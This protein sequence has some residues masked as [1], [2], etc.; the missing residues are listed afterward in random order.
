[1]QGL[2]GRLRCMCLAWAL[3]PF[4][5]AAP[6]L[7]SPWAE[8]GDNALRSDIEILAAAGIIDNLTSHWPLP[9]TAIARKIEAA[10]LA[11]QPAS[12]RDAADRVLARAHGE[13]ADG[14][15]AK[16][17]I[18]LTNRP[19][20]VYDF[21]GMGRGEGENQDSLA[22]NSKY[23]SGRL[24]LGV[25]SHSLSGSGTRLIADDSFAAVKL[26]GALVYAG[27]ITHWWGPGWISALSLSN[28]TE[29]FPQVGIQ[30]LDTSAS[31]WPVLRWL[32]PWQGEFF[33][34]ILDGSRIDNN[35]LYNGLRF[36]FNPAP[37]W[38]IGVARTQ[39][40]CG[41]HHPCDPLKGYFDLSN[42]PTHPDTTANEGLIDVQY[43]R[44]LGGLPVSAYMSLMNE[45]SSPVVHSG[46]T[47]LF[48][49]SI[50]HPLAGNLARLT[51]EYTDSVATKDIFSFGDVIYGYS[52]TD[53]KYLDGMHYR[54]RTL[55]FSLDTDSRLA[56]LQLAWSDDGGRYYQFTFHHAD[57]SD[58]QN[59]AGNVVTSAPVTV[60][61]G[62]ARFTLPLPW[63]KL[64]LAL[65]LQ[66]D[67]PRPERGIAASVEG[68]LHFN[69]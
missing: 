29:P 37:G 22:Y 33:V 51:V 4:A 2:K 47:H 24:S 10:P 48:G 15:Q 26:G 67:Q 61:L 50:W 28:N 63:C 55:G 69:L 52:Y 16:S 68:A 27:E 59:P 60:N 7:A 23:F 21:G 31:S 43:T 1:M 45:D 40:F 11:N 66:D 18:D 38:Q 20:L 14:W 3:V 13:T 35:T 34:G 64:D 46:T 12:V 58:P 62:E 54:G 56:T 49:A 19:N 41:Q 44:E 36:T 6:G 39:E 8:V 9:W 53:Y 17:S 30:R 32:G 57:I 42:N 25:F 65:R 5:P